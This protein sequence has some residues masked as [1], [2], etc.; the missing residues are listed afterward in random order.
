MKEQKNRL[1]RA[2][3][4]TK[5][6]AL[7]TRGN[8]QRTNKAGPGF[9]IFCMKHKSDAYSLPYPINLFYISGGTG[10]ILVAKLYENFYSL[11]S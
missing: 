1:D 11:N 4:D 6:V 9:D 7:S 5:R 3:S 2:A 8:K 10:P